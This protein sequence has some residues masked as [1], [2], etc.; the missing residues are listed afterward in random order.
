MDHRR[1]VKTKQYEIIKKQIDSLGFLIGEE[2]AY[3]GS[4]PGSK[5][6]TVEYIEVE[7]AI[8]DLEFAKNALNDFLI[9]LKSTTKRR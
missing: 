3:L 5:V 1:R 4:L 7:D 8:A 6:N 9:Y 2:Q